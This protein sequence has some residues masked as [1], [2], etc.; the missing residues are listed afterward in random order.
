VP[1]SPDIFPTPDF[2]TWRDLALKGLKGQP[3]ERLVLPTPDGI[4]IQPLYVADSARPRL[5]ARPAPAADATRPW[6]LRAVIDAGDPDTANRHAMQALEGG[7]ASVLLTVDPTGQSGVALGS[8]DDLA[9]ALDGVLLDLAPVAL[10]AGYLGAE[11]A[12]WL[13]VLAKGAPGAPLAFHLDPLS[14]FLQSGESAGPI[15]AHV[16]AAAQTGA[17][18][19]DAYPRASLFLASGRAVHEAGGS[20]VQSL[21][22][23]TAAVV[24]YVRAM[25]DAGL[26][27]QQAFD[28]IVMGVA[29]DDRY[30]CGVATVRAARAIWA[31][32]TQAC[33]VEAPARIEARASRRMLSAKG[34]WNNL[35][36]QTAAA[37]AAGA[38]GADA[39]ILDPFTQPLGGSNQLARRQARNIQLVLM[40]EAATARVADPAGGA[41]F[42]EQMTGDL[43][44]GAWA[45][46]QQIEAAGGLTSALKSG[47]VQDA[48]AASR[49]ALEAEAAS[50][51]RPRLGVDL[52]PDPDEQLPTLDPRTVQPANAPDTRQ[53]G[54]DDQCRALPPMRLSQTREAA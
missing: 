27:P 35:L 15:E 20:D 9:R 2:Q 48:V 14:A 21:G 4:D 51:A 41:W 12:N 36:R 49:A 10:D 45:F 8:Q 54:L 6:D 24:A 34:V 46:F 19:A 5:L 1:N 13:A 22:V 30:L 17:R 32:M 47:L 28:R 39:V 16:N 38:G 23:M 44:R 25:T 43:A 31:R 18:H 53:A 11:A 33:G 7:A 40:E 26:S 42:F 52:H 37:F 3:F 50:G 29:V